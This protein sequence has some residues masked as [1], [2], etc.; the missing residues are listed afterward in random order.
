MKYLPKEKK[1]LIKGKKIGFSDLVIWGQG[2]PQSY[3]FYVLA[4]RDQMKLALCLDKIQE[5]GLVA[6]HRGAV[7]VIKGTIISM[8]QTQTLAELLKQFPN[9][10]ELEMEYDAELKN[11]ILA[12]IA[13]SF[14]RENLEQP[15]CQQ[16]KGVFQCLVKN[17]EDLSAKGRE[18]LESKIPVKFLSWSP[19]VKA[20]NYQVKLKL[21]QVEKLDGQEFSFGLDQISGSLEDLFSKGLSGILNFNSLIFKAQNLSL[22]TL[23]EPE[24][25][26]QEGEDS[27]I[28]MGSE[29]A[30]QGSENDNGKSL[31][32]KFSGLKI[33]LGISALG[34]G[35]HLKYQSELTY[36]GEDQVSGNKSKSSLKVPF[37]TPIKI[38]TVSYR[39]LGKSEV[40]LPFLKDIPIIGKLFV[41][42]NE[43]SNYK[44]IEGYIQ[45]DPLE[46]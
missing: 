28:E 40:G 35:V 17:N 5:M 42:S 26:A 39:T 25:I 23:A 33:A 8:S 11:D 41:S 45:V 14:F 1:I 15:Q 20:T 12:E 32:W 30:F 38:F 29:V 13:V 3:K 4:K 16:S 10:L 21:I 24:F 46:Q 6:E 19:N 18:Y 36:P 27:I 22:S 37:N 7:V 2:S 44:K 31:H 9:G 34:E 43:N